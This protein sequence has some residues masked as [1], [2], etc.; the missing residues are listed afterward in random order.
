MRDEDDRAAALLELR[1]AAEAL[2]LELLVAHGEDLV[3]QEHVGVDVRRDREAEPHV[4]AG[5][6]GA[7][8]QLEVVADAGEVDDLVHA[9]ADLRARETVERAVQ[10]DV[11]ASGELRM[12]PGAEL[13]QRRDATADVDAARAS[14]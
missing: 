10:E 5:R 14:A 7:N 6:V 3:E 4:H 1:D 12:E 2:A 11:L 9:F 13:E 8:G